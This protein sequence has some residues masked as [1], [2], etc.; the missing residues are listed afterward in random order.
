MVTL[1]VSSPW[2]LSRVL[3]AD[4]RI[5]TPSHLLL[6]WIA[7]PVVVLGGYATLFRGAAVRGWMR[8]RWPS[9]LGVALVTVLS[10]A[11]AEVTVRVLGPRLQPREF[12]VENVE[13]S[14]HVSL[15]QERFRDGP[16]SRRRRAGT[17]RVLFIGDSF[18]Y[19]A[20]VG[21]AETIPTL[22]EQQIPGLD[23]FNLGVTGASTF[24]YVTIARR[25]ADYETDGVALGLYVDN[26]MYPAPAP[27]PRLQ[28]WALFERVATELL[29]DCPYPFVPLLHIDPA[30]ERLACDGRINPHLASRAA[31]APTE[32]AWYAELLARWRTTPALRENIL[33]V[34]DL[35]RTRPFLVVLFPSKYQL[36]APYSPE[37]LRLGF[38]PGTV[39]VGDAL[40][41][42][43]VAF[44]DSAGVASLDLLPVLR[45]ARAAGEGDA[46]Y[47]IDDHFNVH[48]NRLAAR[49][50]EPW[51][52]DHVLSNR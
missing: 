42:E 47:A 12:E 40:Q 33:A 23:V 26:D 4:G 35:F 43:M 6:L 24:D 32:A 34:R 37:L 10:L 3:A 1:G 45:A 50:L 29:A 22:L 18:V 28:L 11:V 13:F 8:A 25:F 52:R 5:D 51:I 7:W 49:A 46:Y 15:N 27:R 44:L 31:S 36:A 2:F 17:Q 9:V 41:R 21:Q 30:Y 14:Y 48:G 19:G 16:F 39:P 38:H 20:G